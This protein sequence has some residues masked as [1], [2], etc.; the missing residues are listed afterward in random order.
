ENPH[1][2]SVPG[3]SRRISLRSSRVGRRRGEREARAVRHC[4]E[5]CFPP[6][7]ARPN[8]EPMRTTGAL[9]VLLA[10]TCSAA[11]PGGVVKESGRTAGHAVRDG[12]QTVGRT[13]RDFFKH[14]PRTAKRTWKANA[15]RTKADARAGKSRAK[16]EANAER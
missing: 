3:L 5:W 15:E 14:G 4:P 1:L 16:H 10:V 9:I 13:T 6:R 7:P 2:G 11:D 12:A 8:L